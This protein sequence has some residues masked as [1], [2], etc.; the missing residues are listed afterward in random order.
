[1]LCI[2]FTLHHGGR[3][4]GPFSSLKPVRRAPKGPWEKLE[5][6]GTWRWA[7]KGR[8]H[9]RTAPV[10]GQSEEN[11]LGLSCAS[12]E[13]GQRGRFPGGICG[14]PDGHCLVSSKDFTK[15]ST[16]RWGQKGPTCSQHHQI[17]LLSAMGHTAL[18]PISLS[19]ELHPEGSET[20]AGFPAWS[21]PNLGKGGIWNFKVTINETRKFPEMRLLGWQI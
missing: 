14:R 8:G 20:V 15:S 10:C 3:D 4:E 9:G 2:P 19:P 13:A 1:M 7:S 11:H 18:S 16:Y 5:L 21:G 6:G 12:T 17:T